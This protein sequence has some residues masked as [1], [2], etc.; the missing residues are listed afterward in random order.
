M[1]PAILVVSSV[2]A[3]DDPRI[4]HKLVET[5]RDHAR[6]TLAIAA[7]GPADATGFEVAILPGGRLWRAMLASVRIV[8]GRYDVA[9]VHDPE[10]LP[11]AILAGLLRRRVVFDLHENLPGQL[12]TKEW[13]PTPLRRPLAR[14]GWAV[15]RLAER[16]VDITLAEENYASLFRSRHPV[17]PNYLGMIDEPARER[18]EERSGIVYLG[19]ITEPRGLLTA[20]EAIGR[21]G[22][23]GPLTLIGRC[24]AE[25]RAR[26]EQAAAEHGVELVMTG[27]LT[28]RAALAAVARHA[29]AISPLHDTP[30]YRHSLPTK[31]LEYLALGVP[32]LASDLPGGRRLLDGTPGVV[33]VAPGDVEALASAISAALG[34]EA[35]ARA[36]L[37]G[38]G[39]IRRR[40]RWPAD[41]VRRFYLGAA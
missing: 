29:V 26:L 35:L 9:S 41:D 21:T 4:R 22:S 15:L 38:A 1:K 33:W 30:N 6:V 37:T 39:E 24:G 10:L 16:V 28:P 31:L 2:H 3:P 25:F 40:Y 34:D 32:V 17:F 27:F 12:R 11:A 20:V 36:A 23:P 8:G 14:L 13:V 7:P 18:T 19:D 5:L